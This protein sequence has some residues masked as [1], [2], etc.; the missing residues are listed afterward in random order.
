MP[1][2][3]LDNGGTT[4]YPN[5][6][7]NFPQFRIQGSLYRVAWESGMVKQIDVVP[8]WDVDSDG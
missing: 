7:D 2:F 3:M 5:L 6:I 1:V 8:S 4:V